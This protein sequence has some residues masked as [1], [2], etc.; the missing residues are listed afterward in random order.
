MVGGPGNPP[1]GC[2]SVNQS[3]IWADGREK[4]RT[5]GKVPT[6]IGGGFIIGTSEMVYDPSMGLFC[7]VHA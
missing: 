2:H 7:D 5:D 4:E 3:G 6:W 1:P